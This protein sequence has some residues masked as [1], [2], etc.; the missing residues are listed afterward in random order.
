V[1]PEDSEELPPPPYASEDPEPEA[2]RDLQVRLAAE[3]QAAGN[4]NL[5]EASAR[6]EN[7]SQ[8]NGE[9]NQANEGSSNQDASTPTTVVH[10]PP[11]WSTTRPSSPTWTA[12]GE[13][14]AKTRIAKVPTSTVH[15]TY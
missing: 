5:P 6:T 3:A 11:D 8:G 13:L 7:E 2:T 9:S 4:L 10:A 12:A 14:A 1:N 15:P